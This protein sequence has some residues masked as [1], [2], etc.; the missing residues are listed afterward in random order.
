M[1]TWFRLVGESRCAR[2]TKRDVCSSRLHDKHGSFLPHT[3]IVSERSRTRSLRLIGSLPN[4]SRLS[5]QLNSFWLDLVAP[6]HCRLV[7]IHRQKCRN[8]SSQVL[9]I[10]VFFVCLFR[11]KE[12]DQSTNERYDETWAEF[13]MIG[14]RVCS[15]LWERLPDVTSKASRGRGGCVRLILVDYCGVFCLHDRQ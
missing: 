11:K 10:R 2:F 1:W 7:F 8:I 13:L 6:E 12:N 14:Q 9:C 5:I 4:W 3:L 15:N